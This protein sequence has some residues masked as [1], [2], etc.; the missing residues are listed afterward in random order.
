MYC[1][2]CGKF[3]PFDTM[4]C[5]SCGVDLTA[6]R[7]IAGISNLYYNEGLMKAKIRDLSGAVMFLKKSLKIE[8]RNTN[9]RNLLGL[10]YYEMGETVSALSQWVISKHFQSADNDADRYMHDLQANPTRLDTINQTIKKYNTALSLA[11]QK[12]YDLAVIQLKKVIG[13]N[14][15]YLSAYQ[16]LALLYIKTGERDKALKSLERA[17]K[18]DVNNTMTLR[19]L[20]ELEK[21]TGYQNVEAPPGPEEKEEKK[22]RRMEET[23]SF[24]PV[25]SYR[26]DKPNIFLFLNL[27]IGAL[28][29]MAVLYYLVVPTIEKNLDARYRSNMV[30]YSQELSEKDNKINTLENDKKKLEEKITSLTEENKSLNDAVA[31]ETLYDGLFTAARLFTAGDVRKAADKLIAIDEKSLERPEAKKL[32]KKLKENTFAQ[33]ST[34]YYNEGHDLYSTGKYKESLKLFEKAVKTNG[35]NVDALYFMGRAYERLN[36]RDKAIPYYNKIVEE[37]PDS[38]RV[39]DAKQRLR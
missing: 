8:K 5:D 34:S 21:E 15:K 32:F 17:K 23:P 24:T 28:V 13:L 19:Y 20:K 7:K 18:I 1:P 16:L 35:D 6:Y 39:S 2:G 26:E 4:A 11:H 27:I 37:Y 36:Q 14:P 33:A 10:V 3:L 22:R 12:N 30:D 9:A 25:T 38:A 29:G 31:D